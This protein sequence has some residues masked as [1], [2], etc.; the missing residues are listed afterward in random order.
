MFFTRLIG[1]CLTFLSAFVCADVT[2]SARVLDGDT[3]VIGNQTV[4]LLD[5]DAPENGQ[6]C[7]YSGGQSYNCGVAAENK[8]KSLLTHT[9]ECEGATKDAYDR[10]LATC[11]SGGVNVN[12]A[13]VLSGHAVVFLKFSEQYLS[14]QSEAK[15]ARRGLWEG[16][17][18]M[19]WEFRADRW[20]SAASDA[21]SPECP[22]KGNINRK[23]ER[24]YHAP[25]SRS[26]AKTEIDTSKAERWFCSEAEAL[27]AGWRAP[28]R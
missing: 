11:Y 23:G 1:L 12:R 18:K 22:V 14:E 25:W 27:A 6:N 8:L 28:R 4:R 7:I 21:P 16:S 13:M 15:A 10:L 24:I 20:T 9:V 5:I 26:Y 19:P 3:L 2:G 17:F